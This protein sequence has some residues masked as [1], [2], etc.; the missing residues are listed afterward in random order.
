[1]AKGKKI[2]NIKAFFEREDGKPLE[3]GKDNSMSVIINFVSKDDANEFIKEYSDKMLDGKNP[4]VFQ[5]R[6]GIVSR[7]PKRT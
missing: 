1:M 2:I 4:L 5:F 6:R 7:R 3:P